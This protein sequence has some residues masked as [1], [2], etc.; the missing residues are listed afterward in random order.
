MAGFEDDDDDNAP[1]PAPYVCTDCGAQ[2]P[3]TRTSY[4][5]IS[6]EHGWRLAR[7]TDRPEFV[8]RCPACWARHKAKKIV[9]KK[10][11]FGGK[12]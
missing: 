11:L 9:A 7:K 10:P 5:L 3:A 8:W 1:A 6:S 2:A 4:S 12:K